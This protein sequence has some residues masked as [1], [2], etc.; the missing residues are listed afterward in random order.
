MGGR[1]DKQFKQIAQVLFNQYYN[2]NT[3]DASFCFTITPIQ[4][5]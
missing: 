5:V 1:T 4:T 3:Q 2:T